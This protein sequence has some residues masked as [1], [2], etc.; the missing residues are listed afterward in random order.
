[1]V[2][3]CCAQDRP[4]SDAKSIKITQRYKIAGLQ[5]NTLLVLQKA[6]VVM[7]SA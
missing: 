4:A 2:V 3:N 5:L 7:T 1:M 6:T